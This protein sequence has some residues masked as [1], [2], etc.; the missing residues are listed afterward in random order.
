[1]AVNDSELY[2]LKKLLGEIIAGFSIY[3]FDQ[4]NSEVFV[5]HLNPVDELEIGYFYENNYNLF[6]SRRVFNEEEKLKYLIDNKIWPAAQETKIA[7]S[8]KMLSFLYDNKKKVY[9]SKD[10]EHYDQQIKNEYE[11]LGKI[12]TERADLLGETCEVLAR[13]ETDFYVLQKSFFKDE[14][15]TEF[16]YPAAQFNELS[17][18][19]TNNLFILF[20]KFQEDYHDENIKKLAIHNIF[21]NLFFL[22]ENMNDFFDEKI[23]KLTQPQ[24]KLLTWGNYFKKIFESHENIPD[25]IIDNP[26][27][28]E[29]WHTGKRNI[30]TILNQ[31]KDSNNPVS[32]VGLSKEDLKKYGLPTGEVFDKVL[33]RKIKEKG[34]GSRE[35]SLEESMAAGIL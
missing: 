14:K 22:A 24:T 27:A 10:R 23:S 21:T 4:L 17:V 9:A 3:R 35:L 33:N 5:K 6:K 32:L 18:E 8:K 11:F 30:D 12:L 13:K 25:E 2:K 20:N 29:D 1:M 15:L 28:L 26:A 31:N 7:E 34:G 16:L 19:E